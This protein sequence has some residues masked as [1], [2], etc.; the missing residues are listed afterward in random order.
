MP[1]ALITTQTQLI[2]QG[3]IIDIYIYKRV[4]YLTSGD[5]LVFDLLSPFVLGML[6][7]DDTSRI[8]TTKSIDD[9]RFD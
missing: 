7:R 3:I 9:I 4:Q 8:D 2:D 1:L 6:H 5:G